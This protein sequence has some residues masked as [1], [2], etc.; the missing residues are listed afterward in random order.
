V[1]VTSP[2]GG[3]FEFSPDELSRYSR[4]LILPGVGPEGQR[5]LKEASILLVG[6]G[7]LGSPAGLYL[8]AA[9]V[10][11]LGI[12]DADT[13]D[14]S[15]LQ[16]QVL[17]TTADV[18]RPKAAAAAERLRGLNPSVTIEP[19]A[20]RV[21]AA[22]AAALVARYD[23]VIDA[24]DNFPT[25][26][27]LNDACVLAG[28][29]LLYGAIVQFHGQ[30]SLFAPP[31]G[32][33]YRCLFPEPPPAGSVPNCAEGGVLGVLPGVIGTLQATEAIK[34]I[35][36]TGRSLA[37]RLLL[38]DAQATE[39]T[40]LSISRDPSCPV[41]GERPT[42]RE[43]ADIVE[44][45]APV[46]GV[47]PA[48]MREELARGAQLVDVRTRE[49][50]SSGRI[51]GAVLIPLGEL[52]TRMGELDRARTVVVYCASGSRSA[53]AAEALTKAGFQGVVNLAGG[54]AAWTADGGK[55]PRP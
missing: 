10:G 20:V 36:G 27:L 40:E 49:E 44:A 33:C 35:L 21:S 45:C 26:Y 24:T 28:K 23:L 6:A 37:G 13:I 16:R 2:T 41:C 43:L 54:I 18:G 53:R 32:P 29:P 48:G 34:R 7:G 30:V 5:R 47:T 8:A 22:N 39:F 38:Y 55:A 19:H 11:R 17:F 14:L 52:E 50:W 9:G 12:A 31:E 25:R 42:I 15:N 4:H 51:D 3:A 46:R 1:S